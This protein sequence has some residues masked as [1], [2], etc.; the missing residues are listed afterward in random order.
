MK[1]VSSK[2]HRVVLGC[3]IIKALFSYEWAEHAHE[4]TVLLNAVVDTE[5]FKRCESLPSMRNQNKW[6]RHELTLTPAQTTARLIK[7]TKSVEA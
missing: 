5:L 4:T 3:L 6:A 2:S 7:M 1:H